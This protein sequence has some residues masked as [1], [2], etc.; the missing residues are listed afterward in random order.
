MHLFPYPRV[1]P[2]VGRLIIANAVVMLLLETLFTSASLRDALAFDPGS[3]L[4]RPW[5]LFT[6]MFV[7]QGL[8]HLVTN[9]LG[10]FIFGP[11]VES[12]MGSRR[13]LLFYMVCG[14][15][16][17]IF[18]LAL[19]GI[20]PVNR[21][22]GASGAILGVSVAFAMF[23]PDTEIVLFPI[24]IPMRARTLAIAL[25][26]F[27]AAAMFLPF[28]ASRGVSYV[29]H[30][31]GAAAGYLF[32]RVQTIAKRRP[33]APPRPAERVVMVQSGSG[34]SD[35]PSPITPIRPR[36]RIEADPVAAEM[37]RVLDKISAQ[38]MS[39]LTENERRFLFEVSNRKKRPESEK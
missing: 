10:L 32:F 39:S 18:A 12:R 3:A 17:A 35:R 38:G 25:V 36:R 30:V 5:T 37:D 14:V 33:P 2:W 24:P 29:A 13:F 16:A 19:G 20:V 21:F 28:L 11:A 9:M 7:H 26:A 6:Y 1:T 8:L 15:G 31:G 4:F 34:E 27:N 22:V 23:W